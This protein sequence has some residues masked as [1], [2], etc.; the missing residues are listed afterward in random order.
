MVSGEGLDLSK[1]QDEAAKIHQENLSKMATMSDVDILAEQRRLA[2]TLGKINYKLRMY[3][4][5]ISLTFVG[6]GE[7]AQLGK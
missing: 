7:L 3:Y 5:W 1:A 6:V 4:Y 2:E